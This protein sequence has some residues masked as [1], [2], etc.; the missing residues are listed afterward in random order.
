MNQQSLIA[1][2]HGAAKPLVLSITG[3]GSGAIGA[4]LEVPGGS[5][6]V[7][8]AVVPY[9]AAA[10]RQWL[11]GTPDNY[12]SERTAR[13]MAMAAFERA[14]ALSDA[15]PHTLRGIGATASLVSNRPKRGP[16]RVHI[17]WQ[18][19]DTTA[20]ISC[21]LHKGMR[22]RAEEEHVATQLIVNVVA[23]AC[24]IEA[25]QPIGGDGE[26]IVRRE[27]RAPAAWTELLLGERSHVAI[28]E[29]ATATI[30]KRAVLF[31]GAFNP[32]HAAHRRMAEIAAQRLVAA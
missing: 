17:A 23:E 1:R 24:G 16:H 32:I 15:D 19:A 5:A 2:I 20:V 14:R 30:G 25:S 18:S 28:P 27:H 22:T 12:C 4:L 7:L 10:L 31:P 8:E 26:D 11:V 6:S 9:S 3:G 21:E 13:A 29:R